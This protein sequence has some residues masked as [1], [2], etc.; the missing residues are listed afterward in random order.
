MDI[1][2]KNSGSKSLPKPS[3]L[4]QVA[5]KKQNKPAPVHLL[6]PQKWFKNIGHSAASVLFTVAFVLTVTSASIAEESCSE[7]LTNR[8][9][10]C[11][12]NTR[13]C[14]KVTKKKGKGSWKRTIKNMVKQGAKLS[15]SEQKQLVACLS[16][17][18]PEILEFCNLKK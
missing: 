17:R 16:K 7:L 10:T 6:H 14:Q 12:Y 8:C 9:E 1:Y 11:H 13:V 18:T 4:F 2:L 3:S 15:N 5:M